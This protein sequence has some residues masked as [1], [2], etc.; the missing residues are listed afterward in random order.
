MNQALHLHDK[1]IHGM[2]LFIMKMSFIVALAP[3]PSDTFWRSWTIEMGSISDYS[4]T[5]L[6][7]ERDAQFS[8]NKCCSEQGFD[9]TAIIN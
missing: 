2:Q 9:A 4:G 6:E 1:I 8:C 5:I 7:P 3:H